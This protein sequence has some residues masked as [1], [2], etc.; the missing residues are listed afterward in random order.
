MEKNG[1][2]EK[3]GKDK[4]KRRGHRGKKKEWLKKENEKKERGKNKIKEAEID[5]NI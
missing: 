2:N 5:E 1:M 3:R 4:M